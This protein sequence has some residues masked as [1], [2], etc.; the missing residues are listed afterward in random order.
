MDR[1]PSF[2]ELSEA[3]AWVAAVVAGS[4]VLVVG[5]HSDSALEIAS[6]KAANC[7]PLIVLFGLSLATTNAAGFFAVSVLPV[8][9]A[10]VIAYLAPTLVVLWMWGK[11]GQSPTK[12]IVVGLTLATLGIAL[13]S[14]FVQLLLG[15][16]SSLSSIGLLAA[17]VQAFSYAAVILSGARVSRSIGATRTVFFGYGVAGTVWL[18]VQV[19]SGEAV[20]VF[21]PINLPGVLYLGVIGT[22]LPYLLLCW[23]MRFVDARITSI[24][25]TLEAVVAAT[26]AFVWLKQSLSVTQLVGGAMVLAS[27][28]IVT[29]WQARAPTAS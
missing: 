11:R 1:G 3:R 22:V 23:G 29:V 2:I 18:L 10:V 16:H 4:I 14:E 28:V 6:D 27:A 17:I 7:I 20:T 5:R 8:G 19:I 26:V 13:L 12:P 9:V 21:S 25:T 24:V 15:S